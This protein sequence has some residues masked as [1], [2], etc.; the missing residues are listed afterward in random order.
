MKEILWA[1]LWFAL[2]GGGFGVALAVAA[3]FFAVPTDERVEQIRELLPGANC[4]GCGFSGCDALAQAL[5]E[6]KALPAA[7]RACAQKDAERICEILGLEAAPAQKVHAQVMCCGTNDLA[8]R[9]YEYH[10]AQDCVSAARLGGGD[11]D[12][13][14][15]CVGLGTCVAAC[16]FDAI[17]IVNGVA[18]VDTQKCKG[19][20]VCAVS[21]PK[22]LIKLIPYE[23]KVWVGCM[24][25]DRGVL[26]RQACDAG[27]IGCRKCEKT[28]AYG[29][30]TVTG[31]LAAVD[32]EKC[33]NCGACVEA[34]P[35]KII[36]VAD[37]Y[38]FVKET[39][40]APEAADV[41]V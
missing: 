6:G 33:K 11:K 8:K 37:G 40:D 41:T 28:C 38:T 24:S 16:K 36:R 29:A 1:C 15:G 12:C 7:C 4:G 22:H 34:C 23:S 2:L 39:V 35:R 19:C 26:T 21:C 14:Y 18:D 3:H 9:K 31:T 30:I 13:P 10:G 20:G 27:C 32:Y 17:Q 25:A 5:V